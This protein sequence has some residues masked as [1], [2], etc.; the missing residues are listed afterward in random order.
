MPFTPAHT[1]I[2]LPLFRSKYF[3]ATGLIVGAMAPDFEYF[4]KMSTDTKLG[5]TMPGLFY[6]DLPVS[7]LLAFVF[8]F[9]VK[10]NLITNL[11]ECLQSRFYELYNFDFGKYFK[12]HYF[13]F[14]CSVLIGASSH[15]FW[16]S[17]THNDGYFVNVLSFYDGVI[18]PINGARYPLWYALQ[19]TS[20]YIGLIILLAYIFSLKKDAATITKPNPYY[21]IAVVSIIVIVVF[22][23]FGFNFQDVRLGIFV[24]SCISAI[25]LSITLTGLIPFNS[26]FK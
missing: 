24:I 25:C 12:Q 9:I 17:F 7:C 13:I 10:H 16:D 2:I 15:I 14:I 8:H 3:S 11:P 20:T 4:L 18:V 26:T 6:F 21:W 5:H 22:I 1:A 19:Y 23:R